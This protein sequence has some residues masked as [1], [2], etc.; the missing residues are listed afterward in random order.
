MKIELLFLGKTKESYLAAGLED[1][2]KRIGYYTKLEI[3]VIKE[4]GRKNSLPAKK[5]IEEEGGKLLEFVKKSSLLVVLDRS[6]KQVDSVQFAQQITSWE[7]QGRKHVIFALGG[8]LGLASSVLK[9]ADLI[10]SFSKMTF[11]HEMARLI[12]MEQLYRAFTIKAGE[13]YHK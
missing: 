10:L 2:K 4:Q 7:N 9:R 5:I 11:T 6:G 12:L 3:K 1:F 13:Q 8:P